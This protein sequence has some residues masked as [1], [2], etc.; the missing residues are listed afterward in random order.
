MTEI[1]LL[2]EDL[3]PAA[4][5]IEKACLS[6]AWTES[7][8]RDLGENT[9]YLVALLDGEAVG[10]LSVSLSLFDGEVLNLAV[11][12]SARKR[13]VA[14]SLLDALWGKLPRECEALFLEVAESNLPA[15][16]LYEKNGFLPV[17]RRKNFYGSEDALLLEKSLC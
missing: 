4:A 3:V 6:T 15:R 10:I 8:L 5:A 7:Q 9:L 13:G 17:G 1:E 11:L 16:N 2:R 14:Q 12:P